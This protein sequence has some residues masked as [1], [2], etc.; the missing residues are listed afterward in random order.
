MTKYLKRSLKPK[1]S[2]PNNTSNFQSNTSIPHSGKHKCKSHYLKDDVNKIITNTHTPNNKA[3]E[4]DNIQ[5][6]TDLDSCDR[7]MDSAS[8]SKW[9]SREHEII[10]VKL[11]DTKYAAN[12]PVTINNK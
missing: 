7:T 6:K 2:H 3:T 5:E 12:F 8:D 11:S 4:T 9:L 10:K 1:S